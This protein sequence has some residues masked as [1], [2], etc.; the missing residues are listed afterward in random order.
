MSVGVAQRHCVR[1][2]I[3]AA[4]VAGCSGTVEVHMAELRT[5]AQQGAS[6]TTPEAL[7][8]LQRR[9]THEHMT[10]ETEKRWSDT[11]ATFSQ[12]EHAAIDAM[13]IGLRF[14]GIDGVKGFYEVFHNAFPDFTVTSLREYHMPGTSVREVMIRGTHQ[15]EYTAALRRP[16]EVSRFR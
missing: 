4:S 1:R 8:E 2:L 15:G 9:V 12:T 14:A 11:Y 13:G 10:S 5:D 6:G 16:G 3:A 7:I